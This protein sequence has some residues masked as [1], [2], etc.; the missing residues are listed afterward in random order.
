MTL[1]TVFRI[2]HLKYYQRTKG[3]VCTNFIQLV[4]WSK[5]HLADAQKMGMYTSP[6]NPFLS[7][8]KNNK[9]WHSGVNNCRSLVLFIN[10]QYF[11]NNTVKGELKDYNL[12]SAY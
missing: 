11:A 8:Y 9:K 2:V 3:F 5:S 10:T 6:S 7:S 4:L 1:M 12:V